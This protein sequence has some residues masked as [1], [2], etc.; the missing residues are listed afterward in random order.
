MRK[1]S[2]A[3]TAQT[4]PTRPPWPVHFSFST[5]V[6]PCPLSLAQEHDSFPLHTF[7]SLKT[8]NKTTT[9]NSNQILKFLL[10][11]GSDLPCDLSSLL[12]LAKTLFLSQVL[13]PHHGLLKPL[14]AVILYFMKRGKKET[15]PPPCFC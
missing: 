1:R 9:I 12:L 2:H 6:N 5:S 11:R 10:I 4:L 8:K 15:F 13:Q 7:N 3:E 14:S